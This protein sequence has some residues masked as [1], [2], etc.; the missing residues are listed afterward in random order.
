MAYAENVGEMADSWSTDFHS[1]CDEI[2]DIKARRLDAR[3]STITADEVEDAVDKLMTGIV[4]TARATL[5]V[6]RQS[7]SFGAQPWM[8]KEIQTKIDEFSRL[9]SC[10][11]TLAKTEEA[12]FERRL[13][14]IEE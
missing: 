7:S 6:R 3:D 14:Q 5:G 1:L 2:G 9:R 13:C 10:L 8:T 12:S 4:D 11:R